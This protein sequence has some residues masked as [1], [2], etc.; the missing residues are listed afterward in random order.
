MILLCNDIMYLWLV[1]YFSYIYIQIPWKWPKLGWNSC[2][3]INK[4]KMEQLRILLVNLHPSNKTLFRRFE[5]INYKHIETVHDL[6][7][8]Q[9][10]LRE[11]LCPKSIKP[12]GRH[13]VTWP[14]VE[15]ILRQRIDKGTQERI[16]CLWAW[17]YSITN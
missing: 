5:Q 17:K 14:L 1:Q 4:G 9:N 16:Q 11:R 13:S 10:C 2:R 6:K 3:E 12:N 15:K 7:F 8:N